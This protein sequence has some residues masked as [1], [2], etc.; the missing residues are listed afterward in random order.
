MVKKKENASVFA[1]VVYSNRTIVKK[2][3]DSVLKRTVEKPA[4]HTAKENGSA[5]KRTKIT[6]KVQRM[7][8][9]FKS[10]GNKNQITGKKVQNPK[11]RYKRRSHCKNLKMSH[12]SLI[13]K[14]LRYKRRA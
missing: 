6:L 4:K 14:K 11:M 3:N 1:V 2:I 12:L 5:K 13:T 7:F 10:G 9:E 8:K